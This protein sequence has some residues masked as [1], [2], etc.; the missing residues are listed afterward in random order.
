M[1]RSASDVIASWMSGLQ[2]MR[3]HFLHHVSWLTV[4]DEEQRL[5]AKIADLGLSRWWL[6]VVARRQVELW[7]D[8]ERRGSL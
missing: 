4:E 1:T 5:I 6:H 8:V 2:L 7:L 3:C